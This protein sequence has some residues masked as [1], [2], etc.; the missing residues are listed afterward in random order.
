MNP[1]TN[2]IHPG[3]CDTMSRLREAMSIRSHYP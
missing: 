3:L 1:E 2:T